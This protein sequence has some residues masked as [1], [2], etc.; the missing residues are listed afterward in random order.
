MTKV[1]FIR[2][3]G[4]GILMGIVFTPKL[5]CSLARLLGVK[6]PATQHRD[7]VALEVPYKSTLCTRPTKSRILRFHLAV[8]P[9][10]EG[11]KIFFIDHQFGR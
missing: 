8:D 4:L 10:S 5:V 9:G 3:S 7:A 6:M 2:V 1:L 11:L